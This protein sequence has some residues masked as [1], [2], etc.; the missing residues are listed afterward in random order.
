MIHVLNTCVHHS[1]FTFP[2][3][4]MYALII[5]LIMLM[6]YAQLVG[7]I[8]FEI[9]EFNLTNFFFTFS[10]TNSSDFFM[11]NSNYNSNYF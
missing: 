3:I 9:A 8:D 10:L 5:M 7:V 1:T 6:M 4:M 11:I 2:N